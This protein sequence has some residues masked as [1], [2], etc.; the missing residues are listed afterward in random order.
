MKMVLA[1]MLPRVDARLATDR[2][3]PTRRAITITPS[4][5]MPIVVTARRSREACMKAA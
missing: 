5:G 1:A 2:I 4:E 3:T